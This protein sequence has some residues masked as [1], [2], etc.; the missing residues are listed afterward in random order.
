MMSFKIVALFAARALGLFWLSRLLTRSK[1]RILCYHGGSIGDEWHFN[2]LLFC[3]GQVLDRRLLWLRNKGFSITRLDDAVGMLRTTA[4]RP[5]LP[6]VLTFDDGWYS[7]YANL[8]PVISRHG[9]PATLYLSTGYFVAEMPNLVV[10]LNYLLRKT[11]L[12][13]FVLS[14][15]DVSLD[16]PYEIHTVGERQRFADKMN[17]WLSRSGGTRE[18][19]YR[20]LEQIAS[21]MGVPREA[22]DLTS[23]RFD[24][25]S[26]S[27]LREMAAQGWT[28]ELHGHVHRYPG[29]AEIQADLAACA[30]E[31]RRAGLPAPK[32]YCYP[33]GDHDGNAHRWLAASGVVS[34]TTCIPGLIGQASAESIFYLPRFLDGDAIHPLVFESEASGFSDFLRR[35]GRRR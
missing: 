11:R 8:H 12:R 18:R 16:G 3:R 27:E 34:A 26:A 32:H 9:V 24:F 14:G 33:S 10:V 4:R 31:I 7:T 1:V 20:E 5:V 21:S 15:L 35:V 6:T 25:V 19:S 29:G 22:L 2:P 13:S 28:I 30:A 23:R 17:A